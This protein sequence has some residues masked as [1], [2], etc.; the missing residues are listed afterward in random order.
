M[1]RALI[2]VTVLILLAGCGHRPPPFFV[3]EVRAGDATLM[4]TIQAHTLSEI[5]PGNRVTLLLNGDEIFPA[6]LGAIR[7]ATTTITFANFSYEDGPVAEEM[8]DALAE[9]CR[10]GVGVNVLVDAV[11]SQKMPDRARQA[12]QRSGCHVTVFHPLNPLDLRRFNHRNHRR[13]LVVD[14]RVA[15]SGGVGV[16]TKWTGNGRQPGHWRQ[17]DVMVEGPVVRHVKAAFAEVWRETT[18]MLLSGPPYLPE[19]RRRG[20]VLAQAV[21]S[22]PNGGSAESYTLF[23]LAIESARSTINLTT[24]YFVPD[25]GMSAALAKAAQRGVRVSVLTAGVADNLQ[26]RTVR[27]AS[28]HSFGRA[29]DAGIKIYEYRDALLHS[30][31][32]TIDGIWATVGSTNFDRRSLALNHELNLIFYERTIAQRLDEIFRDD[33]RIAQEVTREEWERR[34]AARFFEWFVLPLRNTL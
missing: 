18:G 15:F 32:L 22:S 4:R 19:P 14:G 5:V 12:M 2:G 25:T 31:T 17:T 24:P 27:V 29:L 9:R 26:D 10:A 8:A 34:R 16:G 6:M 1:T 30:K 20:G 28:R 33:L 7:S 21:M 3:Q 11:G 23:L 13:V